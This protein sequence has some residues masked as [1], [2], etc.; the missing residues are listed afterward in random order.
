MKKKYRPEAVTAL[1]VFIILIPFSIGNASSVKEV[2]MEEMLN[3]CQL[4]F[5]GNVISIEAQ[6]KYSKRI[7][8]FVTYKI[9]EIIKG[10][11]PDDTITLSF[12]GGTVGDVSMVVSDMQFPKVGEHG[13]YFVESLDRPQVHPLL[14]WSQGHFII[15]ADETG[16]DRIMT[17]RKQPIAGLEIGKSRKQTISK[18]SRLQG[19][20]NGVAKG[21]T[22]SQNKNIR[23][24]TVGEFK[25]ALHERLDEMN[26]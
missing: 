14:G 1:L 17:S 7:H 23:G 18:K 25:K 16:V 24:L 12:L 26:E 15:E 9:Q 4:V 20:S 10:D 19:L 5:E 22:F 13:I 3:T 6:Q 2:T 21:I 8:T 11:Y